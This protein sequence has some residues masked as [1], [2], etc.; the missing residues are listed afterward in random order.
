MVPQ[1]EE[2]P[3]IEQIQVSATFGKPGEVLSLE[4]F[5]SDVNGGDLAY[6]WTADGALVQNSNKARPLPS[7]D[8]TQL[9]LYFIH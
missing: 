4:C 1:I 8:S 7:N 6:E 5:A 3:V 9:K 2:P